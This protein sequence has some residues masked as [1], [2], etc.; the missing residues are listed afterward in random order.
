[1]GCLV[2]EFEG[3]KGGWKVVGAYPSTPS[4]DAILPWR[5]MR[6]MSVVVWACSN[7]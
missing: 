2:C 5:M 4:K 6:S 1:M 3:G 7:V